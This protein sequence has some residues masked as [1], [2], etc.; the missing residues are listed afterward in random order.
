MRRRL[1]LAGSADVADE[2]SGGDENA[3]AGAGFAGATGWWAGLSWFTVGAGGRT[4]EAV[5]TGE[6]IEADR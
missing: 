4:G 1:V 2:R 6:A 5:F 3:T